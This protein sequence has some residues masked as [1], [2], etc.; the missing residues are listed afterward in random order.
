M[1]KIIVTGGAGFIGSH[2][3]DALIESGYEV[4]II[5]NMSAGKEENINP[6]AV[7][8][9]VDIRDEGSLI[10]LFKDVKYVFHEAAMP[11]VQYSIE[12]PIETNDINVNGLLNVLEACRLNNVKRIIFASS[13]SIYGDTEIFP[14]TENMKENPMSPYAAHKYIG[15]VYLKLYSKIYGL[16]T[17]CLRY[18]NVYGPRLNPEGAYPLV[19]G[20]F[21]KL[22]SEG[23]P[24]SITGDGKQT[25]DF[26]YVKDV[27]NANLLAMKSDKVGKGEVINIGGG[28]RSSINYIASLIGG[29]TEH[30]V[31][32]IEPHDTQADISKAKELLNW[33]P[34][35]NLE[36]GIKE[37]KGLNEA[38]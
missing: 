6:K 38:K 16:E 1:E 27:A 36:E 28:V 7:F 8:H 12:N 22:L 37:L 17:V 14:T 33:E 21:M 9:K 2:I 26:V 20:Y 18:F 35:M 19:I 30:I 5:D 13:S 10:P 34:S 32:R 4:H 31:P 11:R 25:R 29:E 15:E 3:V 23:K 24:L